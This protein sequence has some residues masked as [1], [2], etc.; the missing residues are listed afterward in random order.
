MEKN[1]N[2]YEIGYL[3]TPLIPEDKLDDNVSNLRKFIEDKHGLIL[4]EGR[5][6]AQKLAYSIKS[7]DSAHFGWVKFMAN[8]E[9]INDISASFEKN[10]NVLRFLVIK[11]AK[12][13]GVVK[14]RDKK[15][16]G[17]KKIAGVKKTEGM[18]EKTGIKSEEIDK[19]LE[20]LLGV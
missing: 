16:I 15:L 11:P 2:T 10:D 20:E 8:S 4:M 1:Q 12:E 3:L 19:K 17:R 9:I 7:F 5:P 14:L 13:T 6:K 18:D